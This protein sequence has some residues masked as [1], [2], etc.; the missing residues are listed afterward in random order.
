MNCRLVAALTRLSILDVVWVVA[1]TWEVAGLDHTIR[2]CNQVFHVF[3][4]HACILITFLY[5][6]LFR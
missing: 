5:S 4:L 2:A 6:M 1:A 3:R